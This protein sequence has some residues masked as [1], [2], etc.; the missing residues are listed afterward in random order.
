MCP[1]HQLRASRRREDYVHRIGGL[2]AGSG[3]CSFLRSDAFNLPALEGTWEVPFSA[4]SD[5]L[6]NID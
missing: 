3:A 2:G 1:C 6:P 4:F 5:L